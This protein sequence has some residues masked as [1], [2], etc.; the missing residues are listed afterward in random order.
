[1]KPRRRAVAGPTHD[2]LSTADAEAAATLASA[3]AERARLRAN[4]LR[5]RAAVA[6][7]ASGRTPA[8][9]PLDDGNTARDGSGQRDDNPGPA[10]AVGS[11]RRLRPRRP[12][13]RTL[14]VVSAVLFVCMSFGASGAMWWSHRT[15]VAKRQRTAE[16]TRVARAEITEL[17]SIDFTKARDGVQR[18][19]DDSTGQFKNQ[20][21]A[22]AD[23]LIAGLEQSK[24]TTSVTVNAVAVKDMTDDSAVVLVAAT[25]QA[26]S[27]Q[28]AQRDAQ[29]F[30]VVLSL[31][32]A[33]GRLK[34]SQVEFV[35]QGT[36]AA[37]HKR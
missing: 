19:I 31:Q 4:E 20:F 24:V 3:R 1:V 6:H 11:P 10:S 37:P 23:D 36:S 33:D 14:V 13:R 16:F 30:R 26:S 17:M 34:M 2:D 32:R 27:L 28:G 9:T 15:T 12:R 8:R 29:E 18:V 25:S 5:R 22:S 7:A 21:Q 35:S